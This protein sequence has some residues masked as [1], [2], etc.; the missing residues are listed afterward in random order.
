MA[1]NPNTSLE[2]DDILSNT[3]ITRVVFDVAGNQLRQV[4]T[5]T[6]KHETFVYPSKRFRRVH[7]GD[8]QT[9][10]LLN[11]HYEVHPQ[12]LDFL[13]QP[14]RI[15]GTVFGKSH[16]ALPDFAAVD[17]GRAPV[18]GEVKGDWGGFERPSALRQRALTQKGAEYLG[19]D[20]AQVTPAS[21]G[22]ETY[23]ENVREVQAHRF[24]HV[25]IRQEQSVIR[26][27]KLHGSLSV[28]ALSRELDEGI[29][30][31]QALICAMMV[32]R[33]VEVDMRR[34][35]DENSSVRLAPK[36]PFVFPRIRL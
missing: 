22:T 3:E 31:A 35:L 1:S 18:L 7:T 25:S 10:L 2:L 17:I 36:R 28:A 14:C 15:E 20:Y 29:S 16:C 33:L 34:Q 5:G 4:I 24:A 6:K 32:R 12:N 8:T 13:P 21:I 23:V 27:L 19:W 26:A 11:M 9:E 30:R